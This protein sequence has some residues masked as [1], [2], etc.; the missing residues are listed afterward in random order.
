MNAQILEDNAGGIH[1]VMPG[2]SCSHPGFFAGHP[3]AGHMLR[4]LISLADWLDDTRDERPEDADLVGFDEPGMVLVA[5]LQGG[6]VTLYPDNMGVSARI[7][8]G[9]AGLVGA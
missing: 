6:A 8:A 9:I 3:Q 1:Y 7:Y 4:D 2:K 5:M